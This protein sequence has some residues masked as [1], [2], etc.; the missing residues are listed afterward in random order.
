MKEIKE[1]GEAEMSQKKSLILFLLKK[2][3][4]PDFSTLVRMQRRRDYNIPSAHF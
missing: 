3:N 2:K 1:P 4:F